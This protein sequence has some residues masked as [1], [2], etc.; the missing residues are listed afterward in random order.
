MLIF[1]FCPAR[2]QKAGGTEPVPPGRVQTLQAPSTRE[3]ISC[4]AGSALRSKRM[5][6]MPA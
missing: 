4:R 6:R 2:R 5:W 3:R 1:R